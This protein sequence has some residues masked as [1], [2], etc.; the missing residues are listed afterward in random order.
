MSIELKIYKKKLVNKH[1]GMNDKYTK[2]LQELIDKIRQ[3]N[4]Y[5]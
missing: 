4:D 2:K 5:Q 3:Y 1:T